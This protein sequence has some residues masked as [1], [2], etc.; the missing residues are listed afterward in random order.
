M[1]AT[2]T[3]LTIDVWADVV[4]PWCYI[5]E[6]RLQQAVESS[7]HRDRIDLRVHTFQLHPDDNKTPIPAMQYLA[8]SHG[9]PEAQARTMEGKLAAQARSEGL[10]FEVERPAAD[11]LDMLRVVQLGN[12]HGVGWQV[13]RAIQSYLFAGNDDAYEHET[14]VRIAAEVGV[15]A[16]EARE[17]LGGDRFADEVRADHQQALQLGARGVPFTVLGERLGIPGA[18]SAAQYGQAIEQAW[19]QVN[20]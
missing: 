20:G 14:L 1:T 13:L 4:C 18:V 9:M 2:A 7:P 15:P 12:Q 19:E 11:T 8:K 5:G 17:V 3:R 16:D 10:V 6:R